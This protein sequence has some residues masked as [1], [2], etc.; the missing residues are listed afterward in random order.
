LEGKGREMGREGTK[1]KR[2]REQRRTVFFYELGFK[3][4]LKVHFLSF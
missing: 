3:V 2:A 1:G 4:H